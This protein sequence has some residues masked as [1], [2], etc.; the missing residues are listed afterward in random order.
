MA[1]F[2][3]GIK[4]GTHDFPL[5]VSK[6]RGQGILRKLGVLPDDGGR[7]KFEKDAM[8]D[9]QTIRTVIGM[10]E[11]FTRPVNFRCTF[12]MPKAIEQQT[13][14]NGKKSGS[15]GSRVK[16]G[17]LDWRTHIMNN[18]TLELFK[19]RYTQ[20]NASAANTWKR[21]LGSQSMNPRRE[22][23]KMN[24]YC[25]KVSIPDK[26]IT[27]VLPRQYGSPY[28]WPT[29]IQ[30]GT[31]TTTFYCDGTMHIKNFFDAWQKLIY[32]DT[33]ETWEFYD[34]KKDPRELKNIFEKKSIEITKYRK[35]LLKHFKEN[36]IKTKI[37]N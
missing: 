24:L 14:N 16:Y 13:L 20:A 29:A 27:T 10:G 2:R 31:L 3:K 19:E 34:L 28:P 37:K 22:E 35:L 18:S 21:I 11:G 17:S 7:K 30:Y 8:G 26:T 33:P 5:S 36:N 9:I 32:N 1:I 25:S 15:N 4:M 6:Q 12:A 23:Q